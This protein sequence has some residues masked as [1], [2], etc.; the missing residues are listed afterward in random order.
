M[1]NTYSQIYV[2][3]VFAVKGR[4]S[5]IQHFI[6]I[7]CTGILLLCLLVVQHAFPQGTWERVAVPTEQNLNAVCFV[8]SL[9]G[10]AVGDSGTILH[11]PDGG[12]T[13]T[14]QESGTDNEII[15]LFFLDRE[16][17]WA[18]AF[19]YTSPPYGTL[20]LKTTNGGL[21]WEN[22]SYPEENIFIN[23]IYYFDSLTGWMG[24]IPHALVNT[25]D[26]GSSWTQA[27]IDT[28]TLA[29]FPVLNLVFYNQ[30]IGYAT[31]GMFDIA[32]VI[33]RTTNGGDLW[34]AIDPSQAPADEVHG[35]HIFDELH[36]MGSGGDP[37]YGYG[38][39]MIRSTDGGLNWEYEEI[40]VQGIA[41]DLDFRTHS[42]AWSP[43]GPQRKL[44]FS[45]DT[46]TT[47]TEIPTPD[48]TSIFDIT[49]PDSLH[50]WGV[51][52]CGAVIRYLPP[53]HPAVPPLPNATDDRVQCLIYP[54]P[55]TG[56]SKFEIRNLKPG[57][58]SIQIYTLLGTE[59]ARLVNK[60]LAPGKYLFPFDAQELPA[61]IYLYQL[62]FNN[63]IKLS[64]RMV[65]VP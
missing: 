1:S 30:E 6:R 33:W 42:Q 54:N 44:I 29:F 57:F 50:G 9:Y 48:S 2:Q 46:G 39:G 3:I 32:G 40:G 64:K 21:T 26:G 35:L 49:F 20:L 10:W 53:V 31:G 14:L 5:V 11:T 4:D 37:D 47:W 59:V 41:F 52:S 38:V 27:A 61:G 15:G 12:L 63:A 16:W 24:G 25:T 7:P 23:C 8:D 17:G 45:L 36:V 34:Y 60:E 65:V 18:S 19:N 13:W 51:G 58:I 56:N 22:E 28:S 55:T 62:W 43:L